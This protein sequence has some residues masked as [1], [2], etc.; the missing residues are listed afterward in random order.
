MLTTATS[1]ILTKDSSLPEGHKSAERVSIEDTRQELEEEGN[2][3][4]ALGAD[5][6]VGETA[7]GDD[8]ENEEDEADEPE[9]EQVLCEYLE[10][11][12]HPRVV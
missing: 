1:P 12:L 10:P 2:Q 7:N 5:E 9:D 3:D 11:R 6:D 4:R 8:D